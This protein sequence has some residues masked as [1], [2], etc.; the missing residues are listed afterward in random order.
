MKKLWIGIL[1]LLLFVPG[2][3]ASEKVSFYLFYGDG[4]PH[5]V[6]EKEWLD[7]IT[8]DYENV[9]FNLLETWYDE[10]HQALYDQVKTAYQISQNGVPL[11]I[12]G[13][14]YFMGFN[15]Y[16]KEEIKKVLNQCSKTPCEDYVQK[17]K[18]GKEVKIE[19]PKEVKPT[20]ETKVK[21]ETKKVFSMDNFLILGIIV[22]VALLFLVIFGNYK[23]IRKTID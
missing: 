12:I 10:E 19:K 15:D 3:K 17:I 5:C 20:T 16:T 2:V 4:C 14:R 13:D 7:T 8:K 18:Q 1:A 11:T 23:N 22:V 21:V 9:E 6:H